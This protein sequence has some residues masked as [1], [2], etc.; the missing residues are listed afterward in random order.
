MALA[1]DMA[2]R[3]AYFLRS[4]SDSL[5]VLALTCFSLVSRSS[6]ELSLVLALPLEPE[7]AP[8]LPLSDEKAVDIW[9][10]HASTNASVSLKK[11]NHC[12]IFGQI[13]TLQSQLVLRI[14]R[15]ICEPISTY[16]AENKTFH[17][18]Y[19]LDKID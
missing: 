16:R 3:S 11:N 1:K 4:S 2:T 5:A 12:L 10:A 9:A 6:I 19:F 18:H 13:Q 7:A 15:F 8:D 17:K 14:I